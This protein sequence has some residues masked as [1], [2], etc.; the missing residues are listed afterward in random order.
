MASPLYSVWSNWGRLQHANGTAC[1]KIVSREEPATGNNAA[2][3]FYSLI[4]LP[5]FWSTI[6]LF[7][8]RHKASQWQRSLI[9]WTTP[10]QWHSRQE[11]NAT[12]TPHTTLSNYLHSHEQKH[13]LNNNNSDTKWELS[14][15]QWTC[16]CMY[17]CI[18]SL[19]IFLWCLKH[20]PAER[21]RETVM[22]KLLL[23]WART[24]KNWQL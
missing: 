14:C 1:W 4:H 12:T 5:W 10:P 11:T 7:L 23:L 21:Q 2:V 24:H 19:T 18:C 16:V 17:L 15:C 8:S 9:S 20:I 22:L 6:L 3:L 13:L